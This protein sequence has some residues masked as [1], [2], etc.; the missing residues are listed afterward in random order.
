MNVEMYDE[1]D[2]FD[3]DME[4][5]FYE[6]FDEEEDEDDIDDMLEALM[7]ADDDDDDLSERRRR[8]GRG[9]GRSRRRRGGRGR[10]KR[11][12]RTAGNQ[13]A[14]RAPTSKNYVTHPQLKSFG[15]NLDKKI[16]RNAKG[17]KTISSR[18][19]SVNSR[20]NGVVSVNR[21]QSKHIGKLNQQVKLDGAL[22]FAESLSTNDDGSIS[23]S[24]LPLLKGAIKSGMFGTSK[25]AFGNPVVI[26]AIGLL[27][28]NPQIITGL[29]GGN[30]GTNLVS[31]GVK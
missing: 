1:I 22:E 30:A 31:A 16:V 8:R 17:I 26:G 9:R 7:E 12:V 24:L 28:N 11:P 13:P 29:L 23:L 27:L 10:K 3:D 6:D 14:Y 25:G 20:V 5:E 21:V 15:A 18:V 4:M 19:S 2:D